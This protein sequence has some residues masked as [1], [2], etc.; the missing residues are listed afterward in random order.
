M[1]Q[2]HMLQIL[3]LVAMEPPPSL[4]PEAIR[5]QKLA[6]LRSLKI[7]TQSE[8]RCACTRAQYGKG[9]IAGQPVAGYLDERGVALGSDTETYVA[10]RAELETWR[11]SGVPFLLRHGKRLPKRFTEIKVQFKVPP[12]KLFTE[13]EPPQDA[14]YLP[15]LPTGER[16]QLR[17]NVLTLSIQPQE[18]LSLSF[19]LK[20]PG[21]NMAMVP[22]S[23]TFDY[24]ERFGTSTQPAYE[25]L[26]LDALLGDLT[27]FLHADEVEASWHFADSLLGTWNGPDAPPLLTYPAGTWGPSEAEGLF[28]G[29]EGNWSQ[30]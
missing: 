21:S 15:M 22:A 24:K 25:R 14:T 17:P 13:A 8:A 10:V 16:C 20:A 26:L 9:T 27:L 18:A 28:R 2:N 30:G 7:P 3:A 4:Q 6:V 12:L 11:W 23:F 1:L 29:C 5:A 19:G